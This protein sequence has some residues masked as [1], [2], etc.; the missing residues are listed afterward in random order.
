MTIEVFW[1][2]GSPYS[3]RVLLALEIKRMPYKSVRLSFS[4]K[5]LKSDAFLAINPRGQ[6]PAIREGAFTLYE[7]I[8]ILCYLEGKQ[9]EPALF[10]GSA[11]ERALIWRSIMECVNYLE[12][13]M[14][15]FA[16][17]IFSEEL[18]EKRGEA[19]QSRQAVEKEI[20]RINDELTH[21]DYMAGNSHVSAAD[22]VLY[23][24]IQLLIIAAKRENTEEISGTL[25]YSEKHY[26][27]LHAWCEKI[28]AIPGFDRTNPPHWK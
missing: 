15:Y 23:P 1:G 8:A 5:D 7:S 16:G 28:E 19:I 9:P 18:P 10:G 11:A 12:P 20:S 3:W 17:A 21:A 22:V 25:R 4:D 26:P 6:V 14:T 24:V 13:H 2:C 27:A